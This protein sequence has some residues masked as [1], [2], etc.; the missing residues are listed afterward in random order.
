MALIWAIASIQYGTVGPYFP[1]LLGIALIPRLSETARFSL[2]HLIIQLQT[3]CLN[4]GL[5]CDFMMTSLPTWNIFSHKIPFYYMC[6][7]S[8][9]N[10]MSASQSGKKVIRTCVPLE[11]TVN[12][13]EKDLRHSDIKLKPILFYRK[14]SVSPRSIYFTC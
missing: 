1:I 5:L 6:C 9:S 8:R 3:Q 13:F 10:V 2:Q 4:Y 7:V 11:E 14:I 12:R